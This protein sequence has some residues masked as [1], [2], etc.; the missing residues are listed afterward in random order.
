VGVWVARKTDKKPTNTWGPVESV[1]CAQQA[2]RYSSY[3][4]DNRWGLPMALKVSGHQRWVET[5]V[6]AQTGDGNGHS[7][8]VEA[9]GNSRYE[10]TEVT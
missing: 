1:A 6:T 4:N 10:H 7:D 9:N 5:Q 3:S 8:E 2:K